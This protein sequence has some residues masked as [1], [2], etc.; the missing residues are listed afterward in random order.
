[1]LDKIITAL[2]GYKTYILAV[3]YGIDA[4][5]VQLGWWEEATSRSIIEQV[6]GIIFVRDAINKSSTP[7][8]VVAAVTAPK[9]P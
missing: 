1:M 3:A 5:G 4:F 2:S 8:E 7:P 6:L 9:V